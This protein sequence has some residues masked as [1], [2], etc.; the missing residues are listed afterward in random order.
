MR[1]PDAFTGFVLTGRL[2]VSALKATLAKLP[3]G[4]TEL[5]CHPGFCDPDL[6]SAA[7]VLKRQREIEFRTVADASWKSWLMERGIRL[8]NFRDLAPG[9]A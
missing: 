9:G 2:S 7:T 4:V 1:T 6:S 8:T 5:M 3:D